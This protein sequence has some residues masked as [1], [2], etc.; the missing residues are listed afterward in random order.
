M[1]ASE[2]ELRADISTDEKETFCGDDWYR[3]LLKCK[4]TIGVEGG[5]SI[6][7]RDGSISRKTDEYCSRH[8][9]ASFDE[10]EK[11]CFPGLDGSLKLFALSPRHLDACMT[12]TCQILI[13]GNYNGTLSPELHYIPLEKDFSNLGQVLEE[14]EVG[15]RKER[16]S[17]AGLR[18]CHPLR[19]FYLRGFCRRNPIRCMQTAY[20]PRLSR[21]CLSWPGMFFCPVSHS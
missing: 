17:R 3:F 14:S 15:R 4:Y 6:L 10:I 19:G 13:K 9:G 16:D 20:C 2:Y 8:P 7:D 12:K 5:A 11:A 18:S 1:H 21:P